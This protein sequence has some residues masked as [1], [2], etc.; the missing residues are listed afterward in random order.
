MTTDDGT[1]ATPLS[2]R[3]PRPVPGAP[4]PPSTPGEPGG[5]TE[6]VASFGYLE[7]GDAPSALPYRAAWPSRAGRGDER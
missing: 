6:M 3:A 2:H 1:A 5:M 7:V 4:P